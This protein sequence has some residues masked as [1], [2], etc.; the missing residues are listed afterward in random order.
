MADYRGDARLQA[1]LAE[2]GLGLTAAAVREIA[3]GVA[4]GPE[5]GDPGARVGLRAPGA[6]G[7]RSRSR[8]GTSPARR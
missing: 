1:L 5:P 7:G 4:A 2:A 6:A 8:T 3:A